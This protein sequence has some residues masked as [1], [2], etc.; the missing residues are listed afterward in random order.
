MYW[1]SQSWLLIN[2]F[3]DALSAEI[4]ITYYK[5]TTIVLHHISAI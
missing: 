3:I 1:T 2:H 4:M 5:F